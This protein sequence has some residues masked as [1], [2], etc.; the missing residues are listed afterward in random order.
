MNSMNTFAM[1]MIGFKSWFEL[2]DPKS[3]DV[4][5]I[6]RLIRMMGENIYKDFGMQG[7]LCA[8]G[9]VN[10]AKGMQRFVELAF[11]GI[12]EWRG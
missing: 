8:H 7:L 10:Y 4:E 5:E 9:K 1:A 2:D 3:G 6:N 12:G 11:D